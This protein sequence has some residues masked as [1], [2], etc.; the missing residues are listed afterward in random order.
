MESRF[1]ADL[2]VSDVGTNASAPAASLIAREL[3][4]SSELTMKTTGG[5]IDRFM[6]LAACGPFNFDSRR[7]IRTSSGAKVEA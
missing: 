4:L 7:P 2:K 3:G 5:S 6:W 1:Q